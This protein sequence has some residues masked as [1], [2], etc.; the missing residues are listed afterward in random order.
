MSK[1]TT[2]GHVY[3][4]FTTFPVPQN[5]TTFIRSVL[6]PFWNFYFYLLFVM[7]LGLSFCEW[8]IQII[9][10]LC[11][12]LHCQSGVHPGKCHLSLNSSLLSWSTQLVHKKQYTNQ[13]IIIYRQS[14]QKNNN[15]ENWNMKWTFV[16]IFSRSGSIY[17][18]RSTVHEW[19]IVDLKHYLWLCG[20][21]WVFPSIIFHFNCDIYVV[22][23]C[24]F[25]PSPFSLRNCGEPLLQGEAL[26]SS[27]FCPT[28]HSIVLFILCIWNICLTLIF[29]RYVCLFVC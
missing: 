26:A 1:H 28:H 20:C 11:G 5:F 9:H 21:C 16:E 29:I 13:C 4:S 12:K 3:R 14:M 10:L 23:C 2:L 19:K 8:R 24:C 18:E 22:V 6:F 7:S 15:S 17:G 27:Q 25:L